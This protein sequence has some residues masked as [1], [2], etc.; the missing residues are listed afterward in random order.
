MLAYVVSNCVVLPEDLH[1][2]RSELCFKIAELGT[3]LR[4]EM[5]AMEARLRTDIL[6]ARADLNRRIDRLEIR[7][8][9][10]IKFQ[11]WTTGVLFAMLAGLYFR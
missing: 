2:S 10:A 6:A 3:V 4:A 9:E 5:S 1:N 11:K 7:F 8:N